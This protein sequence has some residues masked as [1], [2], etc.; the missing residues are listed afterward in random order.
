MSEQPGCVT[1]PQTLMRGNPKYDGLAKEFASPEFAQFVEKET[2]PEGFLFQFMHPVAAFLPMIAEE[3]RASFR[4]SVGEHQNNPVILHRGM[5]ADGR[6]RARELIELGKPINAVVFEGTTAQLLKYLKAENIERR[7]LTTA[8]KVRYAAKVALLPHGTNRFTIERSRDLSTASTGLPLGDQPGE[9][10]APGTVPQTVMTRSEA[11]EE[12]GVSVKSIQRYTDVLQ[13]GAPELD[14]AVQRGDISIKDGASIA[15]LPIEEQ[16]AIIASADP[17]AVKQVAKEN[18]TEK[19][20]TGRERRLKNMAK[21]DAT[22]LL[23]GGGKVGVFYV[24]IPREFVEW[25]KETGAEKSPDNHY[26][27]EDFQFLCDMRDKILA[28]AEPNSVMFMYAWANS[29]QDQLDLMAEWGFAS[30]RRR[31]EA[32]LLLRDQHQN[33]LPAVGEGRY[34]SHQIWAK[35]SS[36]GNL[37][38]GM[39]F[40]FRDC[41]ELLLVGARGDVPAPL[42][43]TQALS[44]IDALTGA[45]SEK[46]NDLFRDQIDRYFPGVRKLEL[47]G[48][49]DDLAAFKARW[50]DWEVI[51]NDVRTVIEPADDV[52]SKEAFA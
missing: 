51:G 48:R 40:W 33:I 43:G 19:A 52:D 14:G 38:Q 10:D 45:H 17:K 41:H 30:V 46:P 3:Q 11:A 49:V 9:P 44:V 27:T 5:L 4:E 34:R 15:A 22:P 21:G 12:Y 20:K 32:G 31:D 8:Q 39:G 1:N 6:N 37:H 25:S 13:K 47:F 26:R 36:N 24:D 28:R 2:L 16:R 29:L 7:H 35:R 50:P 23:S 18:R 42:Q